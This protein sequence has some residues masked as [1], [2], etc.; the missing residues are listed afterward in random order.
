MNGKP[1]LGDVFL[2]GS[3]GA[4]CVLFSLYL[5]LAP[6]SGPAFMGEHEG[7]IVFR[8]TAPA[9]LQLDVE[10]AGGVSLATALTSRIW[11]P[12]KSFQVKT[13]THLYVHSLPAGRYTWSTTT[14]GRVGYDLPPTNR[15]VIEAG[16]LNYAGDFV[17]SDGEPVQ[18]EANTPMIVADLG[19][20]HPTLTTSLPLVE[21]ITVLR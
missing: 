14:H 2:S 18:V 8:V 9:D 1:V 6:R 3:L 5:G 15:F 4:L 13:G 20:A 12:V 16:K 10:H 17:L 11:G 19:T 21:H 7:L